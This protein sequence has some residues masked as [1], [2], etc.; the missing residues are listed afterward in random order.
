MKCYHWVLRFLDEVLSLG[1][2][3]DEVLPLG[4]KVPR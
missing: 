3:V 1:S 4:S 2:K